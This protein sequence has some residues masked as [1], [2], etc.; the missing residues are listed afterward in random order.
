MEHYQQVG[1]PQNTITLAESTGEMN[2]Q[3]SLCSA[4]LTILA[5]VVDIQSRYETVA[6]N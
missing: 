1:E 4:S 6:L 5:V 2:V 3:I